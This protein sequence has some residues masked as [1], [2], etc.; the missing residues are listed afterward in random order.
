ML[1]LVHI[2]E[3]IPSTGH[4]GSLFLTDTH[5]HTHK[6]AQTACAVLKTHPLS[7]IWYGVGNGVTCLSGICIS[8]V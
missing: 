5:T 6:Y 4:I 7:A 1:I 2:L 8:I 3:I